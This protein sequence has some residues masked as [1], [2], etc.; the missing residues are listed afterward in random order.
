M[1]HFLCL[2][3][4]IYIERRRIKEKKK[5][6]SWDN[7]KKEK[8]LKSEFR[9]IIAGDKMFHKMKQGLTYFPGLWFNVQY[10]VYCVQTEMDF[11]F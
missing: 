10:H 5:K 1:H 9:K 6:K 3:S 2:C 7:G 11:F 4:R 8:I